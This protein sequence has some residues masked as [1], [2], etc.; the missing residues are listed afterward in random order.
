MPT[1]SRTVS[2]RFPLLTKE[3]VREVGAA[4]NLPLARRG[5]CSHRIIVTPTLVVNAAP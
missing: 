4:E 1:E 5:I 2:V 3:R